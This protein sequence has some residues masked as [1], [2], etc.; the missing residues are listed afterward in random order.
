[1][2]KISVIL[3]GAGNRGSG[4]AKRMM[5]L[6]GKYEIRGIADPLESRRNDL[7]TLF[8]VPDHMCFSSWTEM[9]SRPKF[10]DCAII[11]TM[12]NMHYQP[13]L[14]AIELGYDLL[15]EKPVAQTAQQCADIALAANRKGVKVLVCHVLRYA[16]FFKKIKEIVLSGKIGE[17]V[18][19]DHTEGIGDQ[20]YVHSYVRGNWHD[21]TETSPI[22]LAK[23]C[24]DIDIIQW[25]INKPCK[26][27]QSFGSL[28]Y[29][30][31]KNAPQ[32]A[33]IRCADGTCP[34]RDTCPF[35]CE[36]VYLSEK[37]IQVRRNACAKGFAKDRIPTDDEVRQ[38]LKKSDYGLC[39]FHAN[40]NM[41]DHQTVNFEFEGGVTACLTM[42]AF[43]R[44]GRYIRIFGTKG[45]LYAHMSDTTISVYSSIDQTISSETVEKTVESI[46]DGHGGGDQGMIS[47]LY[48]YL[49]DGYEGFS[50]ADINTS[51]KNHLIGFAAEQSR[52]QNT[53]VSIDD[54]FRKYGFE[55]NQ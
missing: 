10:A 29:Y 11:S 52:H 15:L 46:S 26:R 48:D 50:I 17:I 7:R 38:A 30:T 45:E 8:G 22:L 40:N 6:A 53:V 32:G 21:E 14:M 43:N 12:D 25:L 37:A 34:Q 19:I 3:V 51:V 4:Y 33:P 31:D 49:N 41:P 28:S 24:H 27:V 54:F 39:V 2:K 20:H 5:S 18:S 36:K 16:P 55:N 42:N 47:D 1:M 44:G 35:N 9:L 13:A 23:C